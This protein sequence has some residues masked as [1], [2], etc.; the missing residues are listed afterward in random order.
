MLV[1]CECYVLS[2]SLCDEMITRPEES[3]CDALSCVIKKTLKSERKRGGGGRPWP[4]LGRRATETKTNRDDDDD[5]DNDNS[6]N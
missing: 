1:C 3:Y 5:N 2:V 6:N 4:A